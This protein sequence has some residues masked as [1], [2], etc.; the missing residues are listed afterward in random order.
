MG[1]I[2]IV[3][4]AICLD[5][6]P[7]IDFPARAGGHLVTPGKL[8]HIGPATLA[9]GGAVSNT[10]LALHRLGI[11]TR[12]MGKIGDDL[13][14]R[15]ILDILRQR[16]PLLAEGLII[17]PDSPSSYTVVLSAPGHDRTFLHCAG[18]SDTFSAA[19]VEI[20]RLADG[21]L[22]HFGYPPLMQRFYADGGLALAD[23]FKRVKSASLATSLDTAHVDVDSPAGQVDWH[24]YLT[25]V[26]PHLDFF[27]PSLDEI[28]FMLDRDRFQTVAASAGKE[29]LAVHG[30][31]GLLRDL[32][33]RLLELGVAV[34]GLKLGDQGIY[35]R[36]TNDRARLAQMGDLRLSSGWLGR[37]LFA[38]TFQVQVVGT[39]GAGDCAV[40]GFLAALLRGRG[41]EAALTAAAG[42]GACNVEVADAISGIPTWEAL[43]NRI[44]HGWPRHAIQ[45]ALPGWR[46]TSANGLWSSPLD[47][48]LDHSHT[49]MN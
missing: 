21:T 33:N 20:A 3:A 28:F 29:H 36:T 12:L 18:A 16:D 34:I 30:G 49:T 46:Q 22:F 7:S 11:N 25:R 9:T 6:I 32:A 27:L 48:A 44:A 35:L 10:G 42:A 14:G 41:P 4:G 45:I 26:C 5:I 39:T 37:E 2:A 40:A 43:H 24:L 8:T 47:H 17:D 19:D 38:P 1:P 23:L 13:F 31:I 15:A